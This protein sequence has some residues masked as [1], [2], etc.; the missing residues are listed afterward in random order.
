MSE[1]RGPDTTQGAGT[2]V[3]PGDAAVSPPPPRDG[4][5]EKPVSAAV[6]GQPSRRSTI[7]RS[8]LIILVLVVVFGLIIPQF[9][10]YQEILDAFAALDAWQIG[11]MTVVGI[12]AWVISGAIFSSLIPGLSIIRGTS[13]WLILSGTG[14][15]I[16][17]GP[18]NMGVTWVVIRGWGMSNAATASGVALY[19]V[20]D[21]LSRMAMPIFVIVPLLLAGQIEDRGQIRTVGFIA[22]LG[23]VGFFVLGGAIVAVVR[24][25]RLAD[26]VGSSAQRSVDWTL[27]K[28]GRSDG[29]DVAGAV[30]RFRD[31]MGSVIRERGRLGIVV[32]ILSKFAW[33]IVLLA[34]LR[35]VGVPESEISTLE[36]LAVYSVTWIILIVPIA[37]GGAGLPELLMISMFTAITGGQYQAEISAGVFLMRIY[38]WF[39][40]IPL[41]WIL[42]KLARR[43]KPMLPTTAELREAA[44][45]ADVTPTPAT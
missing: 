16:P 6:A 38:Q 30:A 43:G 18:W 36:V 11:L 4:N 31:Q 24:S 8:G 9:I 27:R 25:Q 40:P 20:A 29:P 37:P 28:L 26:W 5:G 45:G 21:M 23:V 35:A 32:S 39:I 10:D 34:S 19:G 22:L 15:S 12:V 3:D 2:R 7:L 41:A 33:A 44:S 42:L 13:A 14:A 17:A 1:E